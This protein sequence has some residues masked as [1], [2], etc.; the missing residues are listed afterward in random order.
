M[1]VLTTEP[2]G[3]AGAFECIRNIFGK[4]CL[5]VIEMNRFT[6]AFQTTSGYVSVEFPSRMRTLEPE[7]TLD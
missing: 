2:G 6:L 7:I 3:S 5:C 1:W 4:M